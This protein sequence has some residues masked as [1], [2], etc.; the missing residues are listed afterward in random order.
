MRVPRVV[1][2][3]F[4]P[5]CEAFLGFCVVLCVGFYGTLFLY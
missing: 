2:C 1:W 4:S 3:L 5:W